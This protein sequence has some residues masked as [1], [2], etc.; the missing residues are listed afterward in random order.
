MF[1]HSNGSGDIM[2]NAE[3]KTIMLPSGAEMYYAKFGR[4]KKQLVMIPGLNILDINGTANDLAYFYRKFTKEFTIYVFDRRKGRDPECTLRSM[5]ED[6]ADAMSL[7][8]IQNAYLLGVSQGGM[9]AQYLAA[10]H[11]ELVRSLVLGV[12]ASRTNPTMIGAVDEWL[13]MAESGDLQGVLTKSYDKMYTEKQ[14]KVYRR[15]IPLMMK[16]TKLMSIERF[17][18]HARAIYTL[19]SF[20]ILDKIK[21]PVLVLGAELDRITTAEGSREI[22][23]KLGCKL[24]IFPDEGHAVYLSKRF[25]RMVYDFFAEE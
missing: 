18:D 4:G 6:V 8:E 21:C 16:F 17:A 13:A 15:L 2:Y 12:T 14:M 11:T 20:G 23:G 25:N 24:H 3:N 1:S 10:E 19:D 9:I 5:A 7:L 22:A